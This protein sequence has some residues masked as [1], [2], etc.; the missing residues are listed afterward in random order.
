[1]DFMN[2][3][4]I[5]GHP[6]G[7]A[8]AAALQGGGHGD[9]R[10]FA[11]PPDAA[12]ALAARGLAC[13]R[14]SDLEELLAHDEVDLVIVADELKHRPASLRRTVQAAKHVL[15]VHPADDNP[16]IAYEVGLILADTR[17]A[18]LPILRAA[19]AAAWRKLREL[20]ASGGLGALQRIEAEFA[21][22][23]LPAGRERTWDDTPLP[24]LWHLLRQLGGEVREVSAFAAAEKEL[25]P[26][27]PVTLSGKFETNGLF[28]VAVGPRRGDRL[29]CVG[30]RGQVEIAWPEGRHGPAI[31][32]IGAGPEEQTETHAADGAWRDFAGQL[33]SALAGKPAAAATWHDATRCLE[34]LQA[35]GESV[36]RRRVVTLVYQDFTE[37]ASFKGAM[38]ATGCALIWISII[39]LFL[40]PFAPWLL[41]LVPAALGLFLILQTLRWVVPDAPENR[42]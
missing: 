21:L 25:L 15:C 2:F 36:E 42:A 39:L 4:L 5:G 27:E 29:A 20:V 28:Q 34:L 32:R 33:M 3:A 31:L 16:T 9:L 13:Q 1:M 30:E 37:K 8:V 12:A 7:L 6:D 22:P 19:P 26:A 17:R 41:Y 11:G 24:S 14:L 10:W 40:S 23:P 35:A 18:C 38:T